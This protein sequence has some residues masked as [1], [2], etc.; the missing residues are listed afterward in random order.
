MKKLFL[1]LLFSI[2]INGGLYAQQI[3]LPEDAVRYGSC[4]GARGFSMNAGSWM[5]AAAAN[6]DDIKRKIFHQRALDLGI[7]SADFDL[8]MQKLSAPGTS[9]IEALSYILSVE[10][11]RLL[12]DEVF[13]SCLSRNGKSLSEG[14]REQ[15]VEVAKDAVSVAEWRLAEVP[16]AEANVRLASLIS[17]ATR[18]D[19]VDASG[20][21]VDRVYGE[22]FVLNAFPAVFRPGQLH[23]VMY[24][25]FARCVKRHE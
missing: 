15:C 13:V 18:R 24:D 20:S 8:I 5:F 16:R 9:R 7:Q 23:W 11:V 12:A 14:V 10:Q 25:E 4:V 17:S 2:F 6:G 19:I 1:Y 21:I 22:K 3:K